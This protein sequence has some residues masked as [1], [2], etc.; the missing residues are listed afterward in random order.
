LA[1]PFA[2][3]DLLPVLLLLATSLAIAGVAVSIGRRLDVGA[4]LVVA[5][6]RRPARVGLL[7]SPLRFTWRTAWR[8]LVAW[9]IGLGTYSLVLGLLGRAVEQFITDP[10]NS[11]F[12]ELTRNAGFG[13]YTTVDGYVASLAGVQVIALALYATSRAEADVEEEES[14]RLEATLALPIS[15]PGWLGPRQA[16]A[17]LGTLGLALVTALATWVGVQLGGSAVSLGAVLAGLANVLPVA[18]LSHAAAALAYGVAARWV[19][20]AGVAVA[21]GGFVLQIVASLSRWPQWILDLSP[22]SHLSLAPSEP[23]AWR[24]WVVITGLAVAGWILAV[25]AFTRRDLR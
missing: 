10:A 14:K 1:R 21:L 13:D 5:A 18:L 20:A 25:A 15:R 12:L 19:A 23:V 9:A 6:N 7:G 24:A 4:A 16:V 8:G 17:L 22:Q 11:A 2:A 3:N